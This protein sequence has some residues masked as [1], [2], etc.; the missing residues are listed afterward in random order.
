MLRIVLY[1][2]MIVLYPSDL[3]NPP[4]SP[5]TS[6]YT[7]DTC[8]AMNTWHLYSPVIIT[9]ASGVMIHVHGPAANSILHTNERRVETTR[10]TNTQHRLIRRCSHFLHLPLTYLRNV[11]EHFQ[12]FRRTDVGLRPPGR[13]RVSVLLRNNLFA[14]LLFLK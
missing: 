6:V 5:V 9:G 1:T 11:A 10:K 14:A 12:I 8:I 13:P 4:Y 2:P 7:C 3:Y